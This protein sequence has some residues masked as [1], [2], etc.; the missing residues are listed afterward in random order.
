MKVDRVLAVCGTLTRG[1]LHLAGVT[2]GQI[3]DGLRRRAI[4]RGSLRS[5]LD[6]F[7][8]ASRGSSAPGQQGGDDG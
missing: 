8:V 7:E 6:T 1:S 2:D 3:E 5:P 4:Q